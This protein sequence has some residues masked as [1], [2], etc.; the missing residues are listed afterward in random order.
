M[1]C[2]GFVI[3]GSDLL[4]FKHTIPILSVKC[5]IALPSFARP[6]PIASRTTTDWCHSSATNGRP[7]PVLGSD[8]AVAIS[9]MVKIIVVLIH[10][11]KILLL[12]IY[13][14]LSLYHSKYSQPLHCATPQLV[15]YD[16][17]TM[18]W[19]KLF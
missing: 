13:N 10:A 7:I 16:V 14:Y 4:R 8:K 19:I 12:V 9:C 17:A 15:R 2:A 18:S 3:V 6:T 5:S 1:T 11:C